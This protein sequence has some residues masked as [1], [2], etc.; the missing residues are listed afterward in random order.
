VNHNFTDSGLFGLAIEGP[1]S[2][3]QELMGTLVQTLN[4]LKDPIGDAELARAKNQ[5]KMDVITTMENTENRLEEAARNFMT[6]GDL[7]FQN[8]CEKIDAVS[9]E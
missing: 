5:L 1:G 2:H 8:Y 7:T 4:G 3:S 6:F 9:S